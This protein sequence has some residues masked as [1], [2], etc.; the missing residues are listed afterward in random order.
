MI[1]IALE[2][3]ALFLLPTLLY[4]GYVMLVTNT[5]DPDTGH[6][7]PALQ[8]LEEAPLVWLFVLGCALMIGSLLIFGTLRDQNIDKPYVPAIYRDGRIIQGGKP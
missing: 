8:L 7:K 1:R 4:L 5:L 2:N 3:V 6:H